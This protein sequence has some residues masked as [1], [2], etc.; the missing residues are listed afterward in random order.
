MKIIFFDGFC[1]LC[2]EFINFL[3]NIDKK[4]VLHYSSLQGE[5]AK[6]IIP[7]KINETF[8]FESIIYYQD[9]KIWENSDAILHIFNDLGGI[10]K[11]VNV[12]LLI[13]KKIRN[14]FYRIFAKNRYLLFGK[15]KLCRIPTE[16]EKCRLLP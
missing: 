2:N 16:K 15:R 11:V 14:I 5:T 3:I 7:N 13:P 9:G 4:S 8:T 12:L 6:E 1:N 10:W